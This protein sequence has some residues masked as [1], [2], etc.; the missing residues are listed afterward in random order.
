M[1]AYD[2]INVPDLPEAEKSNPYAKFYYEPVNKPRTEVYK[3][4]Q[5]GNEIDSS[6]GITPNQLEKL[7]IPN[8]LPHINGYCIMPD[9]TGYSAINTRG[10]NITPEMQ[11][12]WN[13]WF[14]SNDVHYKI[15]LTCI[16]VIEDLGWG[17]MSLQM[18]QQTPPSALGINAPLEELNPNCT[19]CFIGSLVC[20]YVDNPDT[21]PHYIVL[22]HYNTSDGEN[23]EIQTLA[24]TGY[25]IRN[26]EFKRMIPDGAQVDLEKVRLIACHNAYEFTRQFD[27]LP[28]LYKH[29]LTL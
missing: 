23:V 28:M 14:A 8:G 12:F 19:G 6:L 17:M 9:G 3:A 25:T 20:S 26:G 24:F 22:I 10:H 11:K 21:E 7:F 29:S 2:F 5:P 27:L 1:A 18:L 15:W 16:P 4:I 13:G